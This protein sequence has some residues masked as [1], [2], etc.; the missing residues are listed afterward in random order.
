MYRYK[1]KLFFV[2]FFL[3]INPVSFA[4][5]DSS[6][7]ERLATE[8]VIRVYADNSPGYGNQTASYN[9][10][11]WLRLHGF[12]GTIEFNY[13]KA[14]TNKIIT[15]FDLPQNLPN[16]YHDVEKNITFID[17]P[18]FWEQRERQEVK[19]VNIGVTVT[20]GGPCPMMQADH[21]PIDQSDPLCDNS[22]DFYNT[23]VFVEMDP[24]MSQTRETSIS[25]HGEAH[26]TSQPGSGMKYY[27][28]PFASLSDTQKYLEQDPKGQQL[29]LQ[30]PALATLLHAIREQK[31]QVMPVYGYTIQDQQQG[32]CGSKDHGDCFPG[33]ILQIINGARIAQKAS[34]THLP[35]VILVFYGYEKEANKL[36]ELIHSQEWG[37]YE[38]PGAAAARK[39]IQESGLAQSF[40]IASLDHAKTQ[41]QITDLKSD[42]IL[43]LYTGP[44]PKVVFD[45]L[46]T[47]T[48]NN[49][50]PAIREGASAFNSL[51]FTGKP[52]FRCL[53]DDEYS[54]SWEIGYHLV[55]DAA[56]KSEL[57]QFYSGFCSGL[58]SFNHTP[59]FDQSLGSLISTAQQP[60]SALSKYFQTVK[61][62]ASKQ[63]NDRI[64]FGLEEAIKKL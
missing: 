18:T 62:E 23:E 57:Q 43:L 61:Q 16:I 3:F 25:K 21:L 13:A 50:L 35:I 56:L 34:I 38:K 6:V 32:V 48:A 42:D 44:L 1:T 29:L 14:T 37:A 36:L 33:N 39:A 15:L 51:I 7:E 54:Q 52:H 24:Y 63:E 12:K 47:H 45:G 10:I 19:H 31:I 40:S 20:T 11:Q 46:Y 5:I 41:Q 55:A 30:K 4:N 59:R 58:A 64:Y 9:V 28:F 17:L 60:T 49:M 2:L 53:N 27:H 8:K 22:A 26:S